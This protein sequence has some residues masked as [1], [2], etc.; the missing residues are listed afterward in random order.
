MK[1]ILKIYFS[2]F[3]MLIYINSNSQNWTG[4]S[5]S[6]WNNPSN[7]TSW[8]LNGEDIIIDTINYTGAKASPLISSASVFTPEGVLIQNGAQLTIQNNLSAN[9][10]IEIIGEGT[11]VLMQSGIFH[12][13]GDGSQGRM[14]ISEGADLIMNGVLLRA[15]QR[16]IVELGGSFILNNGSVDLVEEL[17]IADGDATRSSSV[18]INGGSLNAALEVGF[19]NETGEFYPELQINGGSFSTGDISWF[20]ASPGAG[21]PRLKIAG[22]SATINGSISNLPGSTVN[23]FMD[24]SGAASVAFNGPSLELIYPADSIMQSENGVL[25][26]SGTNLLNNAGVFISNSSEIRFNGNTFLNG[27]GSFTFHNVKINS[28]KTLNHNSPSF[29]KV[30]GNFE[31]NGIF[32]ANANKILINGDTPQYIG[33]SSTSLF[34]DLTINNSG[35]GVFLNNNIKIGGVLEFINGLITGN[36]SGMPIFSDNAFFIGA[37]DSSFINGPAKKIGNDAFVFPVGKNNLLRRISITAPQNSTSEFLAEYFNEPYI[38]ITSVNNPLSHVSGI[39]YWN[40]EQTQGLDSVRSKLYWENADSSEISTCSDLSIAVW[41]GTSWENVQAAVTGACTGSGT[42]EIVDLNGR[43]VNGPITFGITSFTTSISDKSEIFDISIYPNP[44][45]SSGL[46][47]L[48]IASPNLYRSITITDVTGHVVLNEPVKVNHALYEASFAPGVYLITL[49]GDHN[50][51]V[52]KM[53][54]Q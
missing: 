7:W 15:E 54:V 17:A 11:S 33:G 47:T 22:G 36:N 28:G 37:S 44:V 50:R 24:I 51:I 45:I 40:L 20:G 31:N 53:S 46:F 3:F 35:A 18:I 41:N 30:N 38:D 34:H 5:N 48:D 6:D 4:N 8:P 14:I 39:E 32:N 1:Y 52:R 10:R 12:A 25:T 19:E 43:I 21:T 29:I 27:T 23:L 42:G 26:I 16:L 2:I 9:D 49:S 13:A